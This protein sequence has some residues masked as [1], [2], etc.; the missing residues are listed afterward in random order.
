MRNKAPTVF[1]PTG[2]VHLRWSPSSFCSSS[3]SSYSSLIADPIELAVDE[4][5]LILN[6]GCHVLYPIKW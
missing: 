2:T 1:I 4:N 3:F 6:H 5:K